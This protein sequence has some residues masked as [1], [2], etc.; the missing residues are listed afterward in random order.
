MVERQRVHPAEAV[1]GGK[2]T[3]PVIVVGARVLVGLLSGRVQR[4]PF[5]VPVVF[6]GSGIH[7]GRQ[8]LVVVDGQHYIQSLRKQVALIILQRRHQRMSLAVFLPVHDVLPYAGLYI[9]VHIGVSETEHQTV[10]PLLVDNAYLA[11][12]CFIVVS[13]VEAPYAHLLVTVYPARFKVLHRGVDAVVI[14]RIV[15]KR[16]DFVRK[17]I[18][19]GLPEVHVGLMRIERTVRVG[20][21][22]KPAAAFLV[23]NDI[24]NPADGIRAESHRN[25]ALVHLDAV[26]KIHGDIVQRKRASDAFL[27]HAVYKDLYM[28]PAE[29]VQHELHVRPYP[30]RLAQFHSRR[31]GQCI[32]QVSGSVLQL[33][34]IHRHGVECRPLDTAHARRHHRYFVQLLSFGGDCDILPHPLPSDQRPR[35]L[36]GFIADGRHHQ[37]I[38]ARRRTHMIDTFLIGY[39]PVTGPFQIDRR[40]IHDFF[41]RRQDFT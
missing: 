39:S 33:F 7:I 37:R 16:V 10:R 38:V 23:R 13:I 15:L 11:D 9:L 29:A 40:K 2:R 8:V 14:V 4:L 3:V 6:I 26:G 25:Y 19:E 5:P 1:V 20:R 36:Y 34:R 35:F 22:Q 12:N 41:L 28:L 32:A 21:I 30:A 17:T 31:F 27:R 18:L 24:D